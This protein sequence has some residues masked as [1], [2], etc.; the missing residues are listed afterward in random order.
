MVAQIR[1][2]PLATPGP[3]RQ[4][5]AP[6]GAHFIQHAGG[7]GEFWLAHGSD[8]IEHH[9]N[10]DT[11]C[12]YLSHRLENIVRRVIMGENIEL[13]MHIVLRLTNRGGHRRDGLLVVI[14][15][16]ALHKKDQWGQAKPSLII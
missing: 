2:L 6:L 13:H 3:Y 9:P 5:E 7:Y 11:A 15:N 4:H 10:L 8:V 1:A 14:G 12:D 16:V